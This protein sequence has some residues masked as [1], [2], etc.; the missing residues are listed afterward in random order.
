MSETVRLRS[1]MGVS[2]KPW[3]KPKPTMLNRGTRLPWLTSTTYNFNSSRACYRLFA[4]IAIKSSPSFLITQLIRGFRLPSRLHPD[5]T[6]SYLISPAGLTVL[7]V[8]AMVADALV[9]H[10]AVTHYLRYVA[11][12]GEKQS[13]L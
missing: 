7:R 2:C 6:F 8:A 12:T 3:K 4:R 10:P 1:S 5:R 11:T 13:E 9:Y